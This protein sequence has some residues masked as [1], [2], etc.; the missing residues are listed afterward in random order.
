MAPQSIGY[1][2]II[3][4]RPD[5]LVLVDGHS[6]AKG[7]PWVGV[8]ALLLG[9]HRALTA[10]SAHHKQWEPILSSKVELFHHA[11]FMATSL[12][13]AA[14]DDDNQAGVGLTDHPA[15]HRRK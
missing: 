15:S 8:S 5:E 4:R 7:L 12:R 10:G 6:I 9:D 11:R 2:N 1:V 13:G 14:T 3:V